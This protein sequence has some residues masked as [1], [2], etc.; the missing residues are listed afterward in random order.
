M[1]RA[2]RNALAR[3]PWTRPMVAQPVRTVG[4]TV[5]R[6]A[7]APAKGAVGPVRRPARYSGAAAQIGG[8]GR[9]SDW[10]RPAQI[11]GMVKPIII[12]SRWSA[13]VGDVS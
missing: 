4:N 1:T 5:S 11:G 13:T 7:H 10:G 3:Q 6:R 2:E 12:D 8:D 9:R